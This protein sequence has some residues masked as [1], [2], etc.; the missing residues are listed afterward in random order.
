MDAALRGLG[1]AIH[2][3][4]HKEV[5]ALRKEFEQEKQVRQSVEEQ[6]FRLQ[7]AVY[8]NT[9]IDR[10]L[11]TVQKRCEERADI[12]REACDRVRDSCDRALLATKREVEHR[13]EAALSSLQTGAAASGQPSEVLDP[14]PQVTSD[15][16]TQLSHD[17]DRK[18]GTV[19]VDVDQRLERVQG[20]IDS[21]FERALQ[22]A[23]CHADEGLGQVT[24][25]IG[26]VE[27]R[28]GS[29][30]DEV[31]KVVHSSAGIE[32]RLMQTIE[33]AQVGLEQK[34]GMVQLDLDQV[35]SETGR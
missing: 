28:L 11:E 32:E 16:A 10:M 19:L 25:Q 5:G 26:E 35:K 2:E 29:T 1:A 18:L 3:E 33:A 34:I 14:Q 21:A 23:V 22:S 12:A 20:E 27:S 6:V 13:I 24:K 7:Q 30:L 31:Q 4:V 9:E 17:L 15:E 8:S